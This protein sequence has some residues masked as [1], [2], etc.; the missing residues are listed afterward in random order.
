[1]RK[2]STLITLF[3]AGLGNMQ[4]Q[5][6]DL[7]P[8]PGQYIVLLSETAAAPVALQK[9][10]LPDRLN[11]VAAD[12]EKRSMLLQEIN[13]IRKH[14]SIDEANV[15]AEFT[16]A[17][18]GFSATLSEADIERLA[19]EP[20]VEGIYP[21]YQFELEPSVEESVP[22][23]FV[24]EHQTTPCAVVRAGGFQETTSDNWIWI[25]DTGID[26][27]HPD[28]EV[29]AQS[30]FARTCIPNENCDDKHGHGTHLAGIAAAKNNAFGS[31][32][33]SA[34]ATVVPVK[35]IANTGLASFSYLIQGINHVAKYGKP[36]DIICLGMGTY[37]YRTCQTI[38]PALR[39]AILNVANMGI[40]VCMAA[41]NDAGN[42][43]YHLPACLKGNRI[44]TVGAI[45]CAGDCLAASNWGKGVVD[46]VA[47][48]A[49]VYST[50]KNGEYA[51]M[52]GTAQAAAVVAGII[53]ARSGE[54]MPGEI[55]R[56]G[57]ASAAVFD[58]PKAIR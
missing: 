43:N 35:V 2:L 39:K 32:G 22:D 18:V 1:M 17:V 37:P 56:C 26:L 3:L 13:Q 20:L 41:G 5:Q 47:T 44:F 19:N 34:G 25:L 52:S 51:V 10:I 27:D 40:W 30:P 9:T 36:N 33:I 29:M 53:H 14:A 58:Y 48:G 42:A 45:T 57:N 15:I 46:W 12:E 28:L 7:R 38:N 23:E 21:D 8:I 24:S 54:P 11:A 50:Y 55:V 4:A 6:E 16:D 31:V 49:N